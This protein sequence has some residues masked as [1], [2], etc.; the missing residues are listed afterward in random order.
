M[1]PRFFKKARCA[2]SILPMAMVSLSVLAMVAAGA[3]YRVGP[4]VA[5]TYHSASWN[6]ALNSAEAGADLALAALNTSLSD[7][8]AAWAAW[9]PA[10]AITFPKTWVPT[11][12]PHVGDGNNKVY[13]KLTVDDAIVDGN[14]MKWMR[15]RS[16]GVAELP[17]V[18]RT[19]I[20]AG[21]LD[22]AG[23]KRFRTMLRRERFAGDLTG[24]AL[25][26]PQVVR[27]IEA[28]AAPPGSRMYVRAVTVQNAIAMTG[29]A[30]VDS[31][32]SSDPA[33][34][35]GGQYDAAKRQ[36]KGAIGSNDDGAGS[37]LHDC[38]V[39]GDA[40]SNGGAIQNANGVSGNL[41]NNFSASLPTVAAPTWTTFNFTPTAITNPTAPATLVGGPAGSPQLYRLSDL[42]ISDAAS[43]LILTP[44]SAGQESYL[45]IWVTGRITIS[46]SGYIQ[47]QPGVHVQIYVEDHV[48]IAGGGMVNQTNLARNLEVFG[49]TPASGSRNASFSGTADFVGIL[50]AP[51][52]DLVTSG[53]GKFIGAAIGRSANLNSS[54]GLHYD[55]DLA[56][57]RYEGAAE[58]RYVSWIEDVR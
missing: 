31:F 6:D 46:G 32:D 26:L 50:A 41:Y 21:L 29:G 45:K 23:N 42:T 7:P 48:S 17:V 22:T 43:P 27:S 16:M 19:G 10:D 8:A 15:V 44:H 20:E 40:S 55:E 24:G 2:G 28:M 37:D 36:A 4:N 3:I 13:C 54:G 33:K 14:G 11:I 56:N 53:T 58:Y 39:M 35:T 12:A 25:N 49:V 47:Q 51:A 5:S 1:S 52:F 38:L 57:H 18:S 9:T 34:S 30:H